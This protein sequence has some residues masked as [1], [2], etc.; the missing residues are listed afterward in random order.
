M[1]P[2]G[3]PHS[4]KEPACRRKPAR[5]ANEGSEKSYYLTVTVSSQLRGSSISK[6]LV[7]TGVTVD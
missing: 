4:T 5:N 1:H 2:F 6:D 3:R 7:P